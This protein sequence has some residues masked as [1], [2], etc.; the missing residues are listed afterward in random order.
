MQ[1][2]E[3][4]CSL[5]LPNPAAPGQPDL[6][7]HPPK[8]WPSLPLQPPPGVEEG[9]SPGKQGD[10]REEERLN[11]QHVLPSLSPRT[12]KPSHSS[13]DVVQGL[14][15]GSSPTRLLLAM[16]QPLCQ[17]RAC[18]HT[19]LTHSSHPA[20]ARMRAL[21]YPGHAHAADPTLTLPAQVAAI[22]SRRTGCL[23]PMLDGS[24]P[25]PF[26]LEADLCPGETGL[27][28][29]PRTLLKGEQGNDTRGRHPVFTPQTEAPGH[30]HQSSTPPTCL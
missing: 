25:T 21:P 27:E 14:P 13:S 30:V 3:A 9:V 2:K 1:E 18:S 23:G 12:R 7:I 4:S 29:T 8:L 26:S 10:Q 28:Q 20:I 11:H 17:A 15:G 6:S 19:G 5:G 24:S 22:S 16:A